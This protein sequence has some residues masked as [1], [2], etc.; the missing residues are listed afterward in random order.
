MKTGISEESFKSAARELQCEIELIKAVDAKES[1]GGGF[2]KNGDVK[3]LFEPHIF[4]KY[5]RSAGIK[6]IL[7]NI[8]YPVWGTKPYGKESQQ[9]AKLQKAVLIN[10][11]IA[12]MSASWG[13]FQIMGF[14]FK[15]C[16]CKSIQEFVNK[17]MDSEQSQLQLFVNYIINSNLD[18]ELQNLDFKGFARS[19]NGPLHERNNYAKKLKDLY[20]NFK[21]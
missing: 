9:H 10:R 6:P 20:L 15:A 7:S 3:I 4:W 21:N 16:G 12:L 1:R 11:D 2:L 5:L 19:Y 14:N 17:M 18:D 8:C 13:R